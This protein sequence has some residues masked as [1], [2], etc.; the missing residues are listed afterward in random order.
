MSPAE[1]CAEQLADAGKQFREG[2]M[3]IGMADQMVAA[4]TTLADLV[5]TQPLKAGGLMVLDQIAAMNCKVL[6]LDGRDVTAVMRQAW[7]S[8]DFEEG[9]S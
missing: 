3:P 1:E 9:A 4:M 2:G 8:A 7:A 5:E 6:T